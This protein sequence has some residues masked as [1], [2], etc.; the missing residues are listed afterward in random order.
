MGVPVVFAP[1]ALQPDVGRINGVIPEGWTIEEIVAHF[2]TDMPDAVLDRVVITMVNGK[3]SARVPRR[4]WHR[5]RPFAGTQIIIMIAPGRA[6]LNLLVSIAALAVS[7]FFTAGLGTGLVAGLLRGGISLGITALGGLLINA[8]LPVKKEKQEKPTYAVSGWQNEYR[9]DAVVPRIFGTVRYAPPLGAFS[10]IEVV[11]DILYNRMVVLW[12]Y[13]PVELSDLKNGET[14]LD[15]YDEIEIEHRYGYADDAPLTLYTQQMV[16]EKVGTDLVREYQRY[17]NGEIKPGGWGA[18][19][20]EKPIERTTARDCA[21]ALV[22]LSFPSGLGYTNSKNKKIAYYVVLGVR[23]RKEP[24]G[25]WEVKPD[26]TI[27]AK[28]FAGFFRALRFDFAERGAYTIELTRKS[29]SEQPEDDVGGY[30]MLCT[31]AVLQSFRPEY[32]FNFT[33][34]VAMSAVRVKSTYQLNGALDSLNAIVKGVE[35]DLDGDEWV[36]QATQNPASHALYALRGPMLY[37]P[38]ADEFI[39]LDGFAEWHAFCEEKELQY[40]RPH[41]FDESL[42]ERLAAIG[43]AGRAVVRWDGR[44]WVVTI[45]RP[46]EIPADHITPRNS[47][48]ISVS[49]SYFETPH[50]YRVQFVDETN[51][52]QPATREIPFPDHV[53]EISIVEDV[54]APG[55]TNPDQLWINIRRRQYELLHRSSVYSAAQQGLARTSTSGDLVLGSR[56][57]VRRVMASARVKA[58]RD[59]LV[60]IDEVWTMEEGVDYAIRFR[61]F[62]AGDTIGTSIVRTIA[63]VA[64]ETS[65]VQL[66]GTGEKP[67]GPWVDDAGVWHDG[68][69]VMFGPA[70]SDS[71]R[72]IVVEIE[73]GKDNAAILTML[74]EAAIIDELTDAEIPPVWSG[75]VGA[76]IEPSTEPPLAPAF[77]RIETGTEGTGD[78]NGLRV[79]M[80]PG[81]PSPAIID[82]YSIRHRLSGAGVWSGPVTCT[83]AEGFVDITGYHFGDDVDLQAFATSVTGAFG[84]Y[85]PLVTVTIGEDDFPHENMFDFANPKHFAL[86]L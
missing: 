14:S 18:P 30:V 42:A 58:V 32:P 72:L 3:S 12:G 13:G 68:D 33:K 36:E 41:D 4:V 6:A 45:D 21:Y 61:Q 2:L 16:E 73:R 65:V 31:W 78:A 80:A 48:G 19:V 29:P 74:P 59:N 44:R 62:D 52:F 34:P 25:S 17:D 47:S 35:P 15:K 51:E 24:G 63:T 55:I 28:K 40:N 50:A 69:L 60:E 46:R 53:G 75:R 71:F 79:S 83:A 67:R 81:H 10:Y 37:R 11:G 39:D 70:G 64:G 1:L 84:P 23:I 85:G 82:F 43:A 27:R 54:E 8:L 56:D 76:E 20:D 7:T 57:I 77:V 49:A 66:T 5:V 9:P 26:I 38:V 22:I 86:I